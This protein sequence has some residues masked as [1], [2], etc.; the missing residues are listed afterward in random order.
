MSEPIIYQGSHDASAVV[1]IDELDN[2]L[3]S[4]LGV[5]EST[6]VYVYNQAHHKKILKEAGDKLYEVLSP[7]ISNE[8]F[9]KVIWE[10][11]E[12]QLKNTLDHL[13][14]GLPFFYSSKLK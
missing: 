11:A 1:V 7:A 14:N 5:D 3:V 13:T 6:R 12:R 10:S 8:D 4:K 2:G 9:N